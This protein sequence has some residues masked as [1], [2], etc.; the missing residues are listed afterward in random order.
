MGLRAASVHT[1]QEPRRLAYI[2]TG[3][4]YGGAETQLKQLAI[5]L[6]SRGWE[7]MVIP[8]LPP[9]AYV[10]EL[11]DAGIA[12]ISLDMKRGKARARALFEAG[13]ILRHWRPHVVHSFMVHANILARLSRVFHRAPVQISSARN[14]YE[15]DGWRM[16][17]YRITDPVCDMT[18]QVSHAGVE[19]YITLKAVPKSKI[20]MIPNG[21]ETERFRPQPEL[22]ARLR[23][24]LAVN[25]ALVWLAVG[26]LE[27]QKD[28]PNLIRAFARL[29][30]G[31]SNARLL[32]VGEGSRETELTS[33]ATSLGLGEYIR[34]LGIRRDMPAVMNAADAFVLASSW[35]GMPNTLLEASASELP[36]VAT[37]V[38]GSR[39]IVVDRQTGLLV[40]PHDSQAL[41]GAMQNIMGLTAA[42]RTR[43]GQAGRTFV[44]ENFGLRSITSLWESLYS[45]L[46]EQK[47]GL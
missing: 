6:R 29:V 14:I 1:S 2:T 21:V 5:E 34:F 9:S 12:V 16:L 46:L 4:S 32:I 44:D 18:T 43:L 17:A 41:A 27:E 8:M 30:A 47:K 37:D 7:I 24:E 45:D 11:T 13:A 23:A 33:L 26:R 3:L 20:R 15:G 19:R 38:G 31:Q 39:E 25:D 10:K 36:I 28:Y 35:E 42:E 40:P 22:R